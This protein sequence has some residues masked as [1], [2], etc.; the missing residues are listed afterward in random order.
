MSTWEWPQFVLAALWALLLVGK[1]IV[2]VRNPKLSS[3]HATGVILAWFAWT[4]FYAW[5]LNAGG[6]R[7]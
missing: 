1:C 6:F 3:V 4:A 7:W 2:T 5:I